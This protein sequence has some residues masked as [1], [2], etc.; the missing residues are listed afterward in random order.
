MHREAVDLN[1]D[2]ISGIFHFIRMIMQKRSPIKWN[3]RKL[4]TKIEV[5]SSRIV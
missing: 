2:E 5:F 4:N 3:L 1:D